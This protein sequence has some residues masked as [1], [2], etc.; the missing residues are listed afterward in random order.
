M[1]KNNGTRT[2]PPTPKEVSIDDK[3]P[4]YLLAETYGPKFSRKN[5]AQQKAFRDAICRNENFKEDIREL[6]RVFPLS[7][8]QTLLYRNEDERKLQ[9]H[10]YAEWEAFLK[11]LSKKHLSKRT[12]VH[13][14]YR[15]HPYLNIKEITLS[16]Y[17]QSF[18]LPCPSLSDSFR[19]AAE[20][21]CYRWGLE[22]VRGR[23]WLAWL[24]QSW[25]ISKQDIPDDEPKGIIP[26]NFTWSVKWHYGYT[27]EAR[28]CVLTLRQGVS[29]RQAIQLVKDLIPQLKT[30][31]KRRGAPRITAKELKVIHN[32]FDQYDIPNRPPHGLLKSIIE[33]TYTIMKQSSVRIKK[34]MIQ[35]ELRNYRTAKGHKLK[36]YWTREI[37]H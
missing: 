6:Q 11:R 12:Y 24:V 15:L 5:Y 32:Q 26:P 2:K 31:I 22:E 9:K 28:H 10:I 3:V 18:Y 30:P 20:K 1:K 37:N 29:Q 36:K 19:V 16:D 35:E 8:W 33:E 25:D 17:N 21:Y 4:A 13:P 27:P 23:E 7:Y 14:G 34:R